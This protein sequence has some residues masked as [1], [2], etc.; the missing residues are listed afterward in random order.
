QAMKDSVEAYVS[1]DTEHGVNFAVQYTSPEAPVQNF[2][3]LYYDGRVTPLPGSTKD[4]PIYN[5]TF[6]DDGSFKAIEDYFWA[7][8]A[9]T[10]QFSDKD[11]RVFYYVIGRNTDTGEYLNGH[12]YFSSPNGDGNGQYGYDPTYIPVGGEDFVITY[13]PD[14]LVTMEWSVPFS[15]ILGR[16]PVDGEKI[17]FSMT[18][19]QGTTAPDATEPWKGDL[20]NNAAILLGNNAGFQSLA[21]KPTRTKTQKVYN[22]V[23]DQQIVTKCAG[24]L[25]MVAIINTVTDPIG[26]EP[27]THTH[28]YQAVTVDPTCTEPG[29]TEEVCSECGSVINHVDIPALGHDVAEWTVVSEPTC[30]ESG[31]QTGVCS[32]CGEVSV[33]TAPL[34]HDYAP[35]VTAPTCTDS[36]Y[37]TYTCSRCG[38]E[39]TDDYT[40]P[41]GHDFGEW[42]VTVDP[43]C[44]GWGEETRYCSR[45]DAYE[46][47]PVDPLD[48]DYV[49]A[50]TA[51]TCT[52]QGYTTYT[53]S[54]C[55]ADYT[56]DYTEPLGHD[57]GE[58]IV[59]TDPTC[60]DA[61][62]ETRYCSRCDA[63]ETQPVDPLGHNYVVEYTEPTC[64][65][66]GYTTHTCT[67][68]GDAFVDAYV[69]AL[70]HD[71][72]DGIC[73]RCGADDPYCGEA[74]VENKRAKAGDEITVE[75]SIADP[76]IVKSIAISD[77]T[78]DSPVLTLLGVEW[79][80]DGIALSSWDEETG[81]GVAALTESRD[82]NGT[83]VTLTLKVSDDAE[84]GDYSL[85]LTVMAKDEDG[86]DVTF[87]T[88]PGTVTVWSVLRG[89]FNGDEKITDADAIYLLFYTFFPET[90]PLNQEGDINGDGAVT[91][92]DAI[93]V[94]FHT[95][96]PETYPL[97]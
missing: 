38:D 5:D 11:G 57:L 88:E 34:G 27:V 39:Y 21:A 17:G 86:T 70:G 53:C 40:D 60:T 92:A 72:V 67:R 73:T 59:T 66:K 61:G 2:S 41:L 14:N 54:I 77:I 46:T 30:T 95:F 93:Y 1:W 13:G 8:T 45:C 69:P 58:W 80:L 6:N 94:L 25:P 74:L 63:Y 7:N 51:P 87:M 26:P 32:R 29:Y 76:P 65:E 78:L 42:I 35:A 18:L 15:T 90:Y 43:T 84:D 49:P 97:A 31:E 10:V 71:F 81:K 44:G 19:T 64:T 47:Q 79:D 68:C 48:H 50:V 3:S 82:I 89:D 23:T 20:T 28:D 56:D 33:F 22:P 83:V 52:D 9:F 12:Y 62:E 75:V 36:G 96:F 37:T 16:D 4:S 24:N 85:T 91:D 55:G